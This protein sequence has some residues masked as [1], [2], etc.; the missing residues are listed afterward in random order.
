MLYSHAL[1]I[2]TRSSKF[3]NQVVHEQKFKDPLSSTRQVSVERIVLNLESEVM[4]GPGCIPTG[5][6]IFQW[7]F[8]FSCSQAS[9]AYIGIIVNFV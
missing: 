8:W 4:R 5:G 3:K 2:P 6:N 9:D 7:N 1:L